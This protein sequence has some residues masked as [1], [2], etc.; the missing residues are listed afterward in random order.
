MT[1]KIFGVLERQ[2]VL[3]DSVSEIRYT[4]SGEI[5]GDLVG[6]WLTIQGEMEE[7]HIANATVTNVEKSIGKVTRNG[8]L[9]DSAPARVPEANG[10]GA[11]LYQQAKGRYILISDGPVDAPVSGDFAG[12]VGQDV[13]IAGEFGKSNYVLYN[14]RVSAK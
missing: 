13:K 2:N 12:L 5:D 4:L 9:V 14:A 8:L 7:N 10:L 3:L 6:Q 11:Y 1:K